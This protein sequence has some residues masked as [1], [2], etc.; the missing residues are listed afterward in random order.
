MFKRYF[1]STALA[2]ILFWGAEPLVQFRY[3]FKFGP[4]VQEI[5]FMKKRNRTGPRTDPWG[6]P[7]STETGLET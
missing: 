5:A 4:V 1:L 6:T 3:Y 7:D 2:A